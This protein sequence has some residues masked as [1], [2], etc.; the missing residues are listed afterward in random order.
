VYCKEAALPYYAPSEFSTV[1][2]GCLEHGDAIPIPGEIKLAV[3]LGGKT[4]IHPSQIPIGVYT[5]L[6]ELLVPENMLQPQ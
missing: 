5:A 4:P 1:V 2:S 6:F 3:P